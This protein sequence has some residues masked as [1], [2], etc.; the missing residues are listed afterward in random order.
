MASACLKEAMA[1]LREE[2]HTSVACDAMMEKT[3]CAP[4]VV[5]LYMLQHTQSSV[6]VSI[7]CDTH[8]ASCCCRCSRTAS[9]TVIQ[10]AGMLEHGRDPGPQ[11]VL[12]LRVRC[13]HLLKPRECD[14]NQD[15]DAVDT[16]KCLNKKLKVGR[17]TGFELIF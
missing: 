12:P 14:E 9:L 5:V 3:T 10:S 13:G 6:H 11:A 7:A 8:A 4:P 17:A 1:P 16:K 15:R 2:C